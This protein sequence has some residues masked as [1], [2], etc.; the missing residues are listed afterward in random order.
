VG[1]FP[2]D[3]DPHPGRP[4]GQVEQA[5]DLGDVSAPREPRRQR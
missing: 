4:S 5:G 2:A 3:D 1:V